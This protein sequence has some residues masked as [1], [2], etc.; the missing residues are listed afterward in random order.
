MVVQ[1]NA[2]AVFAMFR[3]HPRKRVNVLPELNWAG[4]PYPTLLVQV[5]A[6]YSDAK[7]DAYAS[8]KWVYYALNG[9]KFRISSHNTFTFTVEFEFPHPETGEAMVARITR[10]HMDAWFIG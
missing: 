7:A 1:N 10:D 2:H 3:V 4:C 8:C 9:R 6:S 5:Y